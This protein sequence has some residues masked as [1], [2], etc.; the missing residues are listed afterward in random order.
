MDKENTKALD[1]IKG[2]SAIIIAY[3]YHYRNDFALNIGV[4]YPFESLKLYGVGG[5]VAVDF[6]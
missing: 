2:I 3:F 1:S 4:V 5:G 6:H